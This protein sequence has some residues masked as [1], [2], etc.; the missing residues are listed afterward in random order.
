MEVVRIDRSDNG[1]VNIPTPELQKKHDRYYF[2]KAIALKSGEIYLSP[3]DLNV[4]YGQAVSSPEPMLRIATPIHKKDGTPAGIVILNYRAQLMLDRFV[5]ALPAGTTT[6]F[7]LVN[8]EGYWLKAVEPGF[9]WGFMLNHEKS[10]SRAYPAEWQSICTGLSSEVSNGNGIFLHQLIVPEKVAMGKPTVQAVN[11]NTESDLR[12]FQDL[13]YL[14]AHIPQKDLSYIG[15]IRRQKGA[16]VWLVA[17]TGFLTIAAW[18]IAAARIEK[19]RNLRF[20]QFLAEGVEQGPAAVLITDRDGVIVY[21]NSKFRKM[22][23]YATEEVLGENPRMFKSG[24]TNKEVYENLW[25]TITNGKTWH[26]TF[27]NTRKDHGSYYVDAHISP[28]VGDKGTIEYF[29]AIQEDVTEKVELQRKLKKYATIDTLT[30]AFNRGYFLSRSE[31]E[32]LRLSRYDHSFSLLLFDIDHFKDINDTYGHAA[33][34]LVLK[35]F[36]RCLRSELRD[37]D[38]LGRLGGEEFAALLV[39]THLAGAVRLGQRLLQEVAALNIRYGQEIIRITTSIGCT[40]WAGNDDSVS[41]MLKRAD[42]VLYQA[43]NNGRNR[44]EYDRAGKDIQ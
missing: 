35:Q 5:Q 34:D 15:S 20:R 27:E 33:G 17:G 37:S 23:G 4:E 31:K 16:F 26:G 41:E 42:A 39:E 19:Q 22:T 3:L 14:I 1:A 32:V 44:L 25:R 36:V 21:V 9:E 6:T 2:Q 11:Q 43:K 10:F 29:M 12:E 24:N 30:G 13:W 40:A 28:I 38:I 7:S 8:R 18:Q